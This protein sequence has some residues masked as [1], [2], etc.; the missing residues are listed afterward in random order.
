MVDQPSGQ[1]SDDRRDEPRRARPAWA[2]HLTLFCGLTLTAVAFD[3]ELSRALHGNALS[4][5][6]VFEWPLLA[7]F[8]VWMWW[9]MLRGDRAPSH[10]RTTRSR[11]K[12]APEHESMLAAWRAHQ[13]DL[14]VP[15]P[16]AV[17]DAG[18]TN[19]KS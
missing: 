3:F 1:A 15:T 16:S 11:P 6:Y 8:G 19:L 13:R 12:V 9:K 17:I 7:L 18:P 14:A 5:A 2:I 10:R 4:G